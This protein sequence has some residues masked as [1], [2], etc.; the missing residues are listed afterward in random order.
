MMN[1]WEKENIPLYDEE[2]ERIFK[3][4]GYN[5]DVVVATVWLPGDITTVILL[6]FF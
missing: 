5:E 2:V 3:E 4:I 6:D 1:L